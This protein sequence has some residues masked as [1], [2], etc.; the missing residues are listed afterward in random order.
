MKTESEIR[1]ILEQDFGFTSLDA[2]KKWIAE[3]RPK[4]VVTPELVDRLSPDAIDCRAFWKVC[5]EL[6]GMDPVC[7]VALAP[8]V[9]EAYAP[10]DTM[11]ANRMNLRLAKS[12]GI[13]AFLD[14]FSHERV[15][16]LEIGPGFGSIKHYVET[17]TSHRYYAVDVRPRIP[18]VMEA[19]A[20]GFIPE[21]FV[22][23]ERESFAYVISSNVFQHL[24]A[25]QRTRYLGDAKKLLHKGGLFIF[26]LF[27]DIGKGFLRDENGGAWVDHYGQ[28]TSAPSP[29]DI[30]KQVHD[31]FR[32]LYATQRYDGMVN[33]VCQKT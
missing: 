13:T 17:H 14:E 6:F 23:R 1:R 12:F 30:Q 5:D 24:S 8:A 31:T 10:A 27:V 29:G 7:N 22:E 20:Q 28:L 32:L 11:D 16:T 19:T 15:K 2:Y 26:N 18:G 25:R 3:E 4:L 9:G 33:F 21:D